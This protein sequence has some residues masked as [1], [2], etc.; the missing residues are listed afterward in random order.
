MYLL[1]LTVRAILAMGLIEGRTAEIV[2]LKILTLALI[3]LTLLL[4]LLLLL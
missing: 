1:L 2:W 4:L 3:S